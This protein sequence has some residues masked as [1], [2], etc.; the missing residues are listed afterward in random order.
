M[1]WSAVLLGSRVQRRAKAWVAPT[2]S[3]ETGD[4]EEISVALGAVEQTTDGTRKLFG[5]I[6]EETSETWKPI[7]LTESARNQW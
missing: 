2:V 6:F 4:G 3:A 5:Q 7:L 1:S